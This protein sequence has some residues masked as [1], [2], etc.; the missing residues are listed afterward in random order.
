MASI[1]S[2]RLGKELREINSQGTPVGAMSLLAILPI[3][4]NSRHKH[5]DLGITLVSADDFQKWF[6]TIEVM[7][8]SLYKVSLYEPHLSCSAL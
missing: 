4:Q 8:E 3:G 2:R 1:A 5:R 6:F 7:G